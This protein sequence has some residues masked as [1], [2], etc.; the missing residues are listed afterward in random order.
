M[1]DIS[2]GT[3]SVTKRFMF[4]Y[5]HFLKDH[6]KKC[7]NLHGHNSNLE[8]EVEGGGIKNTDYPNMI[9]DFSELKK[10]VE[11][12]VVDVLDHQFLNDVLNTDY[13]TVEYI[14]VWVVKKLKPIFGD[15]LI[16]VS[17]S[18]TDDSRAEWKKEI[19]NENI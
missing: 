9:I 16:R 14:T 7:K 15:S 2:D 19:N 18:E 8:V 3:L 5:G 10:I 13:P 1:I 11:K 17:V 4:C 12:E 6:K